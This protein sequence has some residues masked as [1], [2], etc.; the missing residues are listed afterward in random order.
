M[1]PFYDLLAQTLLTFCRHD[2]M[3]SIQELPVAPSS[4]LY[5]V[6]MWYI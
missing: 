4:V 3:I 1:F 5:N 6:T 2:Q